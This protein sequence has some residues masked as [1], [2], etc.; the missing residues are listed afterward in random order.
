MILSENRFPLFEDHALGD[1]QLGWQ[2][3]WSPNCAQQLL[4][5]QSLL[6]EHADGG[7]TQARRFAGWLKGSAAP[8]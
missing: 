6:L 3:C 7:W 4:Q 8:R 5:V 1:Q 2:T